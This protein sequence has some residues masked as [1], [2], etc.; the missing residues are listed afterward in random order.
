M[1]DQVRHDGKGKISSPH[2][3]PPPSK[4][5]GE[6]REIYFELWYDNL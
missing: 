2:P 4:E 5:E 1:P 3:Y 6:V